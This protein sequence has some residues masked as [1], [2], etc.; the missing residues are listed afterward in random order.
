MVDYRAYMLASDH[1]LARK[2][3]E[4]G[5]NVGRNRIYVHAVENVEILQQAIRSWS[6]TQY[7]YVCPEGGGRP[8]PLATLKSEVFQGPATSPPPSAASSAQPMADGGRY[9]TT[10]A[11]SQTFYERL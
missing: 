7:L 1:M 3:C 2:C 9:R 5:S 4:M 10:T 8:C 6:T 11:L